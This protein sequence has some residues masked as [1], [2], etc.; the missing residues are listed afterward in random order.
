MSRTETARLKP[1]PAALPDWQ[2]ED[3]CDR[4]RALLYEEHGLQEGSPEVRPLYEIG[5]VG[6]WR[7]NF[8]RGP[9][10][11]ASFRVTA[12]LTPDGLVKVEAMRG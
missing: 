7:V 11:G 4:V 9:Y 12:R 5:G 6:R 8:R 3:T 2:S 10:I 1:A